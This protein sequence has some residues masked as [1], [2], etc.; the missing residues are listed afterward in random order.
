MKK[1]L[2][3]IFAL[4]VLLSLAIPA[5]MADE[6]EWPT[7]DLTIICPA[8]AGGTMDLSIRKIAQ[9]WSKHL[10]VKINVENRTGANNQIGNTYFINTA[11]EDAFILCTAQP[12][13]SV[14]VYCQSAEYSADDFAMLNILA[15]DPGVLSISTNSEI[16]TFEELDAYIKAHPGEMKL[17]C[18]A[19]SGAFLMYQLIAEKYGWDV[20]HIAYESGEARTAMLGGHC[21]FIGG[22]ASSSTQNVETERVLVVGSEEPYWNIPD[23]PTFSDVM[24]TDQNFLG[25]LRFIGVKASFKEKYPE[26]YQKL[27]DTL[28]ETYEDPELLAL[29]NEVD[30]KNIIWHGPEASQA[31][32]DAFDP[33]VSQYREYLGAE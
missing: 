14:T 32:Y 5:T 24:G 22:T 25:T 9:V 16:K 18:Q 31:M 3:I 21:D 10:G 17:G 29:Y 2:A 7:K 23:V 6:E 20:K 8:K 1:V 19:V 11:D 4:T 30:I 26:R 28:K 15:A 27:V 33:I 13:L 12:Q